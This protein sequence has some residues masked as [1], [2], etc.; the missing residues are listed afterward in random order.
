MA[1]LGA[2][3]DAIQTTIEANVSGLRVYDTVPDQANLP[4]LLILPVETDFFKAFG[5]GTDTHQIDLF[6][7]LSRTVPRTG[8]DSLDA[9][10]GGSGS[11]SIRQAIFNNQGL[12][13]ADGTQA[14]VS[15]MS[16][17]GG[18]FPAA[19]IDHIGA[20]LRLVV[21]TPGTA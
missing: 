12:G 17:Y 7:M 8:Q 10:V 18:S 19:G 20:A 9:Y 1:A 2:I 6:V 5:R 16:R 4:A 13:L 3:R 21:T 14:V 15:G 11:Q